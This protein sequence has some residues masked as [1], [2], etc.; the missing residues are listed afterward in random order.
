MENTKTGSKKKAA[1][2]KTPELKLTG[3]WEYAPSPEA[4]DHIRL[5]E[6][7]G[8]FINGKF[9]NPGRNKYFPSVNPATE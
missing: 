3:G 9:V 6:K 5:K 2:N 1:E 8:L 4:K 7:Y